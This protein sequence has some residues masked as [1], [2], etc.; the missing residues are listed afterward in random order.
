M[1]MPHVLDRLFEGARRDRARRPRRRR[2][3]RA[4]R[5]PRPRPS[6]PL[7][8][9]RPQRRLPPAR[10][11]SSRLID[12]LDVDA[13]DHRHRRRHDDDGGRALDAGRG[14]A[15]AESTRKVET[16]LA[17]LRRS[18]STATALLDRLDVGRDAR[19]VTPLMFEHQLVDEPGAAGAHIVLP[20][21]DGGPDPA[22]RRHRCC[23]AGIARPDPARRPAERSARKAA[24]ARRGHR[25][26]P[27]SSTRPTST[28][29]SGSPTE[30]AALRAHKGVT[31]DQAR[32]RR[33]RPV[34]LRHDDGAPGPGRRHG[35]RAAITHHRAHDPARPRG[36]PHRPRRLGRLVSVF[37]MCLRRPGARLRRLRR[38]PR[39]HRRAA[40]RH[41][42]LLGA[43]RRGVRHRAAGGDAV[44][45]DRGRPARAP[46][47]RRSAPPPRWSAS[48]HRSCSVEGPIQYDAAVDPRG[49]RDQAQGLPGRRPRHGARLPRPQHRQQHLQGRAAQRRRRR[50]RPGAAGS[51]TSRS[52]TC[53]A[54]PSCATSSTPS[55]SP[56]SRRRDAGWRSRTGP[57]RQ[58]R[59]V[60]A[61]VPGGRR[62]ITE[63][64]SPSPSAASTT[65]PAAWA[66]R[67]RPR[68]RPE[69][70]RQ[71]EEAAD[72]GPHGLG[73]VGVDRVAGQ[74]HRVGARRRRRCGSR[75]RR[76]RGRG[77]RR[78]SRP[79]GR[80]A[81]EQRW[82]ERHVEERQTATTPGRGHAVAE[83]GQ[84]A[85]VDQRPA[86]RGRATSAAY[87]SVAAGVA[88]TST[89]QPATS[90]APSTAF[91]PS[92]RNSRRSART[93][94]RLSLRAS[95][96]RVLPAVSGTAVGQAT[97]VDGASGGLG[98]VDVLGQRGLGGLDERGERGRRR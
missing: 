4:A 79:A 11:R 23:A 81:A 62:S 50:H 10:R 42:D 20:E 73:V 41:R 57:G 97:T 77:R 9:D 7:S 52:T 96:T 88:K 92:A 72:A 32:D 39:P 84:R 87:C 13:A 38:Q 51:A 14:P 16:A 34:L 76:C 30:Y 68:G 55:P 86:R 89:T 70:E 65:S 61:E 83:G 28:C 36:R 29:A 80:R 45:L 63:A 49:R 43:H 60:V 2:A 94:R 48:G 37:L 69:R 22:G 93:E 95:L 54:A 18:T 15:H 66:A 59:V 78:R 5:A 47:S 25:R 33:R 56:R 31:L 53:P 19:R 26:R 75:C 6:R 35:L 58:R 27:S 17:P 67:R 3:R 46:T 44:V 24:A 21:G 98:G 8:G 85:V 12:G 71:V 40:R 82:V 91:G 90:S 64:S 1:T 74:H